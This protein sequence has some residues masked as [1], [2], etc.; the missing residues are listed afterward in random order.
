MTLLTVIVALIL[1]VN[2]CFLVLACML[3]SQ[4]SQKE[5]CVFYGEQIAD[6]QSRPLIKFQPLPEM[7]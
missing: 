5:D 3:S 1:I 2:S 7:H 6:K 4:V